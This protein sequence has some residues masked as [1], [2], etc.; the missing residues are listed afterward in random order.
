MNTCR[1]SIESGFAL[2]SALFLMVVLAALGGYLINAVAVQHATPALQVES[3]RALYAARTGVSWA[4][5][6][7]R[8]T[9][10]CPAAGNFN[11]AESSLSGFLVSVNCQRSDHD[12]GGAVVPYFQLTVVAQRGV[13]GGTDFVSRSLQAK[14]AGS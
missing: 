6:R 13:Y 11:L 4:A 9:G 7:V 3:V 2:I 14:V 5:A 10:G 8:A 12:L 1:H